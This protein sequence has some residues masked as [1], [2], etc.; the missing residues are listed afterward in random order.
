MTAINCALCDKPID[1]GFLRKM[2][3]NRYVCMS[4]VDDI[5]SFLDQMCFEDMEDD[6]YE[7]QIGN[8]IGGLT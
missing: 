8:D 1:K 2:S 6:D 3:K 7:L 4:C 5:E